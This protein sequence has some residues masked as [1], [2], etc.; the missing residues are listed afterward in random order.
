MEFKKTKFPGVWIIQPNVYRD[1]RGFFFETYSQPEFA[2]H[3]IPRPFV[4]DNHSKSVEQGVLRGLHFQLPP[5]TQGKLVRVTAGKVFDVIVDL[6]SDS[7]SF[8]QWLSFELSAENFTMLYIPRGFAHGFLTM[9]VN[10]EFIYKV[11]AVYAP[12]ADSGIIWND[13]T[14][15]I[16]WPI[17]QPII[18]KK[19]NAH[20]TFA[21]FSSP[22]TMKDS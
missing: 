3:G 4:Q 13:P 16:P 18:S 21:S 15:G 10:T 14:L 1:E 22:F 7:S 8:G 20:G 5:H 12:E 9:D 17:Q 6:R 2:A 19:D 11:D